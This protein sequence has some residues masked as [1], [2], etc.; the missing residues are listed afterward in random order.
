MNAAE[1][2]DS[3]AELW[4]DEL[5][6]ERFARHVAATLSMPRNGGYVL[7]V[8]CGT[9]GM[10]RELA[11]CGAGEVHG[12]DV[13]G[14]MA[15]LAQKRFARDPRFSAARE[16]FLRHF[17]PGYDVIMA[18]A[19]YDHFP[20]PEEFLFHAHQLLCPGG[21]LTVA[22][23]A[24]CRQINLLNEELPPG[25]ARRLA[26]AD[27]EVLRWEPFFKVDCLCDTDSIYLISG[28]SR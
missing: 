7:D 5:P 19:V 26:S 18:F 24:D 11:D 28:I 6:E 21:R 1:Y 10:F 15:E 16:D 9:G 4:D 17:V 3:V 13:S 12:I 14:K 2:Y 8:G 25:I 23:A 20:D 22:F 27:R